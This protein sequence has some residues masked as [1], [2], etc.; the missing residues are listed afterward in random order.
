MTHI[1]STFRAVFYSMQ[2]NE[3]LL[4]EIQGLL[5][6]LWEVVPGVCSQGRNADVVI[7]ATRSRV[8][9]VTP[10]R[11]RFAEPDPE[12]VVKAILE[13]VNTTLLASPT[14]EPL[15]PEP[16]QGEMF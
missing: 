1:W 7:V 15:P 16:Q 8:E 14:P 9:V 6:S 3:E 13:A 11:R 12:S 4:G 10:D 2:P 5:G